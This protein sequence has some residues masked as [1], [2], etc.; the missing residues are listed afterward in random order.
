MVLQNRT[1]SHGDPPMVRQGDEQAP[2]LTDARGAACSLS[3][4]D[5]CHLISLQQICE[6]R[7][8]IYSFTNRETEAQ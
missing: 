3:G 1:Q 6:V 2:V 4:V 8:I 7:I 5:V